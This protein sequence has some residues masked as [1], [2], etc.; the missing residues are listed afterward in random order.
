MKMFLFSMWSRLNIFY[1]I[2]MQQNSSK[3][4]NCHKIKKKILD[5][6]QNF[7]KKETKLFM[8][9]DKSGYSGY[10]YLQQ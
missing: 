5:R 6:I 4:I 3:N 10:D 2:K 7:L 1:L 8:D 9:R